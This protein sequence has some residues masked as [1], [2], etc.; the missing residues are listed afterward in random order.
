MCRA[1][2]CIKGGV[3]A[4]LAAFLLALAGPR[5][6]SSPPS[7][8]SR[9]GFPHDLSC[10]DGIAPGTDSALLRR[11]PLD[12]PVFRRTDRLTRPAK[13]AETLAH[14]RPSHGWHDGRYTHTE[15]TV[16]TAPNRPHSIHC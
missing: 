10:P 12:R 7:R 15:T 6:E 1:S 2:S 3:S 5:I 8:R 11:R 14:S 4:G 13:T 9:Y 16:T